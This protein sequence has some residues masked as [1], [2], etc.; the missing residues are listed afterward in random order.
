MLLQRGIDHDL[1]RAFID[2]GVSMSKV[3]VK[4]EL[5]TFYHCLPFLLDNFISFRHNAMMI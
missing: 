5:S 1:R 4:F 3:K 2:F